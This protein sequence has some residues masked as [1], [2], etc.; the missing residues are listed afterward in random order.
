M[1]SFSSTKVFAGS[2]SLIPAVATDVV[3]RFQAEG[4]DVKYEEMLTGADISVSKGGVFKSVLGLKTALKIKM[5]GYS[6]SIKVEAGVGIFGQQAI[7]VAIGLFVT[8]PVALTA[9]WGMIKQSKLDDKAMGYV[10]EA[11]QALS[12][13]QSYSALSSSFGNAGGS[14]GY[15]E[16]CGGK[17]TP[18]A[19]FCSACGHRA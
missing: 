9:L 19:K 5:T 4:Y 11:L 16:N 17:L 8:W 1:G 3:R 7:P 12:S 6:N 18:G 2:P 14:C 10:E 15:C 13:R